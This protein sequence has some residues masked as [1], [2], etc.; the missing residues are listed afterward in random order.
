MSALTKIFLPLV[1][2]F[3]FLTILSCSDENRNRTQT[4]Q[5]NPAKVA[6][7]NGQQ[8][9]LRMQIPETSAQEAQLELLNKAAIELCKTE[10][11]K[12]QPNA[13]DYVAKGRWFQV[14]QKDTFHVQVDWTLG[15]VD[16][17]MV[18]DCRI[19]R[20]NDKMNVVKSKFTFAN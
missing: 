15:G 9:A 11:L 1:A 5:E 17:A 12:Q 4:A 18:S 20:R 19:A 8:Y 3:F 10:T 2:G 7:K 6:D 16:P 13:K 14:S